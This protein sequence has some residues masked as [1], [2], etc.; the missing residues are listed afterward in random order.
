MPKAKYDRIYA[1]LKQDIENGTYPSGEMLPSENTL[2][3]KYSCSRNTVRRAMA[4]L[5]NGGYVQAIHGKGVRVIYQPP[6]RATFT[7]GRIESFRETAQRNQFEAVTRVVAF[8]MQTVDEELAKQSGLLEGAQV[9]VV[10]RVRILSGKPL[11]FD[12]NVFRADMVGDLTEEI[13]SQSIY[14]YLE[15]ELGMQIVA[16]KRTITVERATPLEEENLA[17]GDLNCVAVMSS[18]TFNSD[19]VQF[20]YTRSCHHPEY[21]SF[22]DMATRK[23]QETRLRQ[24]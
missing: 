7:V 16:S 6:E 10:Q 9:Y 19:G 5:T 18:K 8:G 4:E 14:D 11:I 21:F 2:T 23:G 24:C 15:K 20:E 13:A 3:D 22:H 17:L 12:T 1:D